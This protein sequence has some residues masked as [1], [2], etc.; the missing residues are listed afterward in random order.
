MES[1]VDFALQERYKQ[2]KDLGD[3]LGELATLIEW[4]PFREIVGDLYTNTTEQ[5]GRPNIEVVLMIKLLV[6]QSMYGLSDPELERQ[7]NDKI[8][9]FCSVENLTP[10]KL[11]ESVKVI[12][13]ALTRNYFLLNLEYSRFQVRSESSFQNG[14]LGFN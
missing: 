7:A 1:L 12:E 8:S 13:N 14:K 6:L 10:N 2:V 4:E 9:F 5:G 3:R 11:Y